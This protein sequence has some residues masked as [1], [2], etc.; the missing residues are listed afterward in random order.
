VLGFLTVLEH[1]INSGLTSFKDP[2][3]LPLITVYSHFHFGP[4]VIH[5]RLL[6]PHNTP[7]LLPNK[8]ILKTKTEYFYEILFS[9]IT[10]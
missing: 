6:Y 2:S 10:F 9:K 5:G 4:A 7:E 1:N 3:R 8:Q